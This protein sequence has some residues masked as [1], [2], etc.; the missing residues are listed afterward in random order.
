MG[1]MFAA[2]TLGIA[3]PF[4]AMASTYEVNI[5]DHRFDPTTL[6]IPAG[7]RVKLMVNNLDPTVEEFEGENFDVEKIIPGK[8]KAAVFVGPLEP[9]EYEF[10]GEFH[11]DTAKGK[12]IVE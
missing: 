8:S 10:I 5:K 2:V 6:T 1:K 7:E 3:I 11:R 12:L 4:L 9:G